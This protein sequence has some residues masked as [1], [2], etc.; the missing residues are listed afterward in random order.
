MRILVVDDEALNRKLLE[1][2][3]G[4][5]GHEILIAEEG[6]EGIAMAQREL[7]DLILMDLR[8]PVM[9]GTEALLRL[10]MHEETAS[11]PVWIV[12]S[13]AMPETRATIMEAGAD[14]C[15][16]KPLDIVDFVKRID[17]MDHGKRTQ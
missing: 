17:E 11:I 16:T 1:D 6:F 8:M 4:A 14:E 3:L 10:R 5:R 15:I 2:V 13:D 9:D 7:P 12:T